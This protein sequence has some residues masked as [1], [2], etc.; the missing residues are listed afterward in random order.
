MEE[1]KIGKG[2]D[3]ACRDLKTDIVSLINGSGLPA[4]LIGYV[5]NDLLNAVNHVASNAIAEQEEAYKKALE[6]K[7]K[8]KG[9]NKK[10]GE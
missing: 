5:L 2:L 4:T 6:G 10:N 1:K 9:E 8:A 3:L 7:E